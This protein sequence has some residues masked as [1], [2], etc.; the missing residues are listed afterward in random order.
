VTNRVGTHRP[1]L[2]EFCRVTI[3]TRDCLTAEPW[4]SESARQISNCVQQLHFYFG[5]RMPSDRVS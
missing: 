2:R 4:A 5:E 1:L 3:G